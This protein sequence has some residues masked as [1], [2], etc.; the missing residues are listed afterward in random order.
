MK[1]SVEHELPGRLRLRC[2]KNSF[3]WEEGFVIGAILETQPGV[4]SAVASHRTG[5][6]LIH[7][8]EDARG[9]VLKA[10]ELMDES[11]YGE[12][13]GA[14]LV[15]PE[16]HISEAVVFLIGGALI[17]A[18]L[19]APVRYAVT[20]WHSLPLIGRGLGSLLREKQ[21]NVSVLDACA[22]GTSMMRRDFGT[23]SLVITLLALGGHLESWTH[24]KTKEGLAE[25]LALNID[26][27]WVR[28][29]GTEERINI[30]GLRIGDLAVIRAGSVIPVDGVIRE[31]DAMVNQSSMTGESEPVHRT[32]G[33][34][35][36]AGTVIEAGELV[37][38]VTAFGG[39]TR[40]HKIVEMI[41][42]S[43]ALKAVVQNRAEKMADVIV[44][45][46]FLLAGGT[47]LLT[48][49]I[50]RAMSALL[51]DYSCALKLA[52]PLTI[53]SAMREGARRGIVVKGGK[54]LELLAEADTVVFDKTGTLTVSAPSV[55]KVIP[56]EGYAR[57]EVLRVA[58]CLEE[59][60]PHSIARAVVKQA[61][62]EG[63]QHNELHSTVEY[64]VAHGIVTYIS[65]DGLPDDKVLLGSAHFV[66]EDEGI[67]CS[68]EQRAI[69]RE[70]MESY[71]V[72]FLAI[73]RS[74]A[75]ILCIEDP[76]RKEA[77]DIAGRLRKAG[78]KHIAILTGDNPR[79]AK[80]IASRAGI[81]EVYSQLLPE[82]KTDAVK[83]MKEDGKIVVM[84]GDGIND[85]PALSAA[86]VGVALRDSADIAQETADVLLTE[87]NLAA[88]LDARALGMGT[89]RKIYRNYALIVGANSLLLAL[90]I[91]GFIS[92][93]KSALIH[94]LT[95][96][97]AG[98]YALM[99]VLGK[100]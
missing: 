82:D 43:E 31:G 24:K 85:T 38:S 94:N 5:S 28:R 71:S 12:I 30:S 57:D 100:K 48:R 49:D 72:L 66:L 65:A 83:R 19:P 23:A 69:V 16:P 29:N 77:V 35:V 17:R 7:C 27:L 26:K 44:P 55:A 20:F 91:G 64:T 87:N 39:G 79:I 37:V 34:S 84:V 61:E 99:P 32:P 62:L 15:P 86:S 53:L 51:V 93:G 8:S 74:L 14:P 88:L 52:T 75:G 54:F 96:I 97:G 90:G 81:T 50:A 92:P 78:I 67:V 33:M 13:D 47:Y 95:T 45:Y 1:F 60:F 59:H 25:S 46:S 22:V 21:L 18:L 63:L 58:A 73:G 42:E 9:S 36:Y 70:A 10:V 3:T 2:P 11:F 41:G 98:V 89:M 76:M 6:L 4:K 68:D 40:I 80:H 56:F